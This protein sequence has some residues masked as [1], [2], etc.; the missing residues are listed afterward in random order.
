VEV[1]FDCQAIAQGLLD[2]IFVFV[3]LLVDGV[4][5]WIVV[6]DDCNGLSLFGFLDFGSLFFRNGFR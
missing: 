1:A 5:S 2:P 4:V 6:F 3:K